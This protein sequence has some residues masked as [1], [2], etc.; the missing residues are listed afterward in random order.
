M[1]R[2]LPVVPLIPVK[3][4]VL[5]ELLGSV[6]S[7]HQSWSPIFRV[8]R[9]SIL[10]RSRQKS[11]IDDDDALS[12]LSS[13]ANADVTRGQFWKMRSE[14]WG[15]G[16]YSVRPANATGDG[17]HFARGLSYLSPYLHL[18]PYLRAST[19]MQ[20]ISDT[21]SVCPANAV[22]LA[23]FPFVVHPESETRRAKKIGDTQRS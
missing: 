1:R 18:S 8:T 21:L 6:P 19:M 2:W 15:N 17:E 7:G 16:G 10:L 20:F 5:F 22:Y 9:S 11:L 14:G 4:G 12:R 13:I 23:A 3:I